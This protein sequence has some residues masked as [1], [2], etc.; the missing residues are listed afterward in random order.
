MTE[1]DIIVN[2]LNRIQRKIHYEDGTTIEF[3]NSCLN[4]DINIDFDEYGNVID[5]YC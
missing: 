5:I 2:I 4:E 3:K 1:K